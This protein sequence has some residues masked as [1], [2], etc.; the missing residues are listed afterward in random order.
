MHCSLIQRQI[1]NLAEIMDNIS[2]TIRDRIR[3]KGEIKALTAQGR[4]SGIV[5]GFIPLF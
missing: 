3:I 4:L 2:D 5:I 1:G